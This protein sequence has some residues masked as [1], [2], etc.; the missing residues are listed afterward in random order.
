M[1]NLVGAIGVVDR[2]DVQ[3]TVRCA[4]DLR[5]LESVRAGVRVDQV[6]GGR[7]PPLVGVGNRLRV[8]NERKKNITN[9]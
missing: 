2:V 1:L 7:V 3:D 8:G 5:H 9:T 6:A 4:R